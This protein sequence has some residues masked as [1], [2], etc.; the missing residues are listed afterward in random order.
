MPRTSYGKM[1]GEYLAAIYNYLHSVTA[2]QN[3]VV[4]YTPTGDVAKK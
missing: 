1:S 2:M 4:K 3:T